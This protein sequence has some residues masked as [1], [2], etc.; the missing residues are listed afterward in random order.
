MADRAL[1]GHVAIVTGCG[2]AS[3]IGMATARALGQA[4]V[5]IL[6][7]STTDRIFDRVAELEADGLVASGFVG[8][9]TVP[10][11][12]RAVAEAAVE[13]HGRVDILVNNAG[14]VSQSTGSDADAPIEDLSLADWDSGMSRNLTTAFLMTSAVLPLMRSRGYGRIVNV[15]STTGPVVAMPGQSVYAAAKAGM[16][17]MSRAVALEV[18][19][20]GITVNAVAPGW[21]DTGSATD[22]E[23]AAGR[24]TPVGRPGR[25][26]EVAAVIRAFCEPGLSYVTGQLLVVDGGNSITE[27]KRSGM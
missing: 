6:V 3:G 18:A 10:D 26:D 16:V 9:L 14:M 22:E 13:R 27:D 11:T 20:S 19:A 7:T 5:I 12:A 15:A 24:A 2:S 23:R 1:E 17:G 8:D 4:G 21:I 25:A